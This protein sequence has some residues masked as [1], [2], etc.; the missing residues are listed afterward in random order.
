MWMAIGNFIMWQMVNFRN[1]N[2]LSSTMIVDADSIV[3]SQ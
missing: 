2:C 1:L 3:S